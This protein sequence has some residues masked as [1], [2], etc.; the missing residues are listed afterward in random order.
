MQ[1]NTEK[2]FIQIGSIK[3]SDDGTLKLE[4]GATAQGAV[5]KDEDAF[6]NRPDDICYI[7]ELSD[8]CYTKNTLLELCLGDESLATQMFYA[9]DWQHPETFVDEMIVEEEWGY[10]PK[11]Q[12]LYQMCGERKHCPTCNEIN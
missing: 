9:L 7:P 1:N 10:C 8:N 12:K 6:L 4:R 11:C 5:F 3:R 2:Q